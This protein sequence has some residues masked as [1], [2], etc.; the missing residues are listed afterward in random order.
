MVFVADSQVSRMEDNIE[1]LKALDSNL[2]EQGYDL[3]KLPFA[4]Q[5]NKRDTPNPIPR[6]VLHKELNSF[7]APEFEAIATSGEGVFDTFKAVSKQILRSL[8]N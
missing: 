4:F 8:H 2:R 6:E 7:N 5:F 3:R 1:S